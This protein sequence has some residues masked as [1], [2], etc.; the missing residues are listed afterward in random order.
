MGDVW[1]MIHAERAACADMVAGLSSEQMGTPSLCG[2]WSVGQVVG[3]MIAACQ[4]TPLHFFTGLAKSG[5]SFDK[6]MDTNADRCSQGPTSDLAARLRAGATTTNHPPGPVTAM[7]GEIVIHSEDVRRPLGIEHTVPEAAQV[8]VA[9]FYKKSNLVVG[10]KKRIT[11]LH[12]MA[13]DASWTHGDGP[14]VQGPLLSLILAMTGRSSGLGQ[15]SGEGTSILA[16]RM[17]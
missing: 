9:E 12:L 2:G 15:L 6:L 7:L 16:S 13:S 8:A 10:A 4:E 5:F 11:G 3:H 14:E 17:K 1:P